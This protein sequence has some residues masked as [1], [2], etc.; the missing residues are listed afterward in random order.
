MRDEKY[1]QNKFLRQQAWAY[2][3]FYDDI[4]RHIVREHLIEPV[5]VDLGC[6]MGAVCIGLVEAGFFMTGVDSDAERIESARSI[7]KDEGIDGDECIFECADLSQWK[8]T[9][10]FWF[11]ISLD[12]VEHFSSPGELL[13]IAKEHMADNAVAVFTFPP[14]KGPFGQHQQTL[15]WRFS[16]IPWAGRLFRREYRYNALAQSQLDESACTASHSKLSSK[17]FEMMADF[18]GFQVVEKRKYLVRPERSRFPVRIPSWFP[19]TLT[20]SVMYFLKQE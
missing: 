11:V 3:T 6:G 18:V 1:R 10:K 16:K 7:A 19:D 17:K 12:V 2:R 9:G 14:W 15:A 13:K 4:S 5:G 8:E 20:S